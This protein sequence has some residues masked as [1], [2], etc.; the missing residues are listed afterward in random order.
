MMAIKFPVMT[1][2]T[3]ES[4]EKLVDEIL[5]ELGTE[6]VVGTPLGIGKANNV[7]NEL[8]GRALEKHWE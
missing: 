7:L 1:A 5:D 3:Y 2:T 8:V 6:I 4:C